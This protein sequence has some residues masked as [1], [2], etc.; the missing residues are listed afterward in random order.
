MARS[1]GAGPMLGG[2]L[3]EMGLWPADL[4][5]SYQAML[6]NMR[7]ATNGWNF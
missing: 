7:S 4:N 5:A 6:A 3:C 1:T 2:F